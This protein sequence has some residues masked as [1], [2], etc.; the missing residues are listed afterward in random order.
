MLVLFGCGSVVFA[1]EA[2]E[3]G[4]FSSTATTV[5]FTFGLALMVMIFAVGRVSGAHFNPA[6]SIGP[7]CSPVATRSPRCGCS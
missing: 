7:A 2:L 6:R 3:S 4:A 5:G 1:T